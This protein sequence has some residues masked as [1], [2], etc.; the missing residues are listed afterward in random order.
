MGGCVSVTVTV[1]LNEAAMVG[2]PE[3]KPLEDMAQPVGRAPEVIAKVYGVVPPC[4]L[5]VSE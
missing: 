2:V 4:P 5:I 3:I 1:K